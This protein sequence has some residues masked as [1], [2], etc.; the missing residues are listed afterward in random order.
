[1]FGFYNHAI[2]RNYKERLRRFEDELEVLEETE[3]ICVQDILRVAKTVMYIDSQLC[4]HFGY[5]SLLDYYRGASCR[6]YL[7]GIETP[8]FFV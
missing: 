4:R 6:Y 2:A 5:K 1:M 3:G 8:M 7:H